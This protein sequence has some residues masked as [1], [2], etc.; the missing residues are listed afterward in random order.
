MPGIIT[1]QAKSEIEAVMNA[2]ISRGLDVGIIVRGGAGI[3]FNDEFGKH[4]KMDM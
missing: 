2:C 1:V 4:K 3:F